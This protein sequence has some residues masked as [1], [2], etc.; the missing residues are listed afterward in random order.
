MNEINV[1]VIGLGSMGKNHARVY[2]KMDDVNLVAVCDVNGEAKDVASEFN[3]NYYKDHKEMFEKEEI[4]AV[5]ICVPTKLHKRVAIDAIENKIN[6]LVEKPIATTKEEAKEI[7][8]AAEKNNV[9]LMIGH[10][11]RFNPVIVE[12]K[13]RV[14]NNE[15]G[16]V[17]LIKS[18]RFSPF[19]K[20]VVDVGV[21]I[22]L[23]V[24]DI[25]VMQHLLGSKVKSVYG[26]NSQKIHSKHE[27]LMMSIIKFS[28]NTSGITSCNWI[29]P[30][31]VRELIL[32]GEKGM[33]KADYLKQELSFF[34]NEFVDKYIDWEHRNLNI[35]EGDV[36]EIKIERKE[37][38]RNELEAFISCIQKDE[39]PPVTG[40][41]GLES[42]NV[43]LKFLESAK[44]NEV[45]DL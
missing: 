37:P 18:E 23:S 39:K 6:V 4:D 13:R 20:R 36:M 33:F 38:L 41:D 32:I 19:P 40:Q 17:F 26:I 12:L 16:N 28:D 10:V 7:I 27:D 15:L 42:L 11:E 3:A 30:K 2:S 34:K 35:I 25:D 29:T 8:D 31:I 45:I 14:E 24:H 22:D 21:T 44:T 5:S 9:K 1:A 43:A